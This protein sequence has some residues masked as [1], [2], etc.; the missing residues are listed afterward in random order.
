MFGIEGLG[1]VEVIL[2]WKGYVLGFGGRGGD[3]VGEGGV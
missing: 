2:V 1:C 3:G